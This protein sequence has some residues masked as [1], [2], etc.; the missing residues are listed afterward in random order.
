MNYIGIK[1]I[2]RV[3]KFIR[4]YN[5]S[6][7]KNNNYFANNILV[8]NCF[9]Y[10][11][12][13][14][15]PGI[16]NV[17][18]KSV[19]IDRMISNLNGKATDVHGKMFY[20]H[21]YRH[22]FVL[23]WGGLADPFCPFEKKNG[24]G[25][26]LIK[27]LGELNY[28]TLFSFKGDAIFGREYLKTFEKH[29]T[30]QNFAFQVSMVTADDGI[31]KLIE[32]GVPSPSKRFKIMKIL[33]DMGYWTILRLRPFIVG[34][35]D[36]T[37]DDLLGR[38]LAAGIRA[39]SVEFMAID[40][41]ANVGMKSRYEWI[42]KLVGVQ[43]LQKYFKHTSPPERGGYMRSNRL[44]KEPFIKKIYKFCAK[45]NLV[46]GVSDPDFKELNTT[47]SCCGMPNKFPANHLLENWTRSQTT[48]HLK[49]ARQKFYKTKKE[50]DLYFNQVYGEE[51]YLDERGFAGDHVGTIG[52]CSAVTN[53]LTHRIMLQERWNNLN[54]PACPKNYFHGKV[55]PHG[56]DEDGNFIF[57][58]TP[59]DYEQ[60]WINE[61]IDLTR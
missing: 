21:F 27:A 15:N 33:S 41:R 19:D 36:E 58:Y 48:Y 52:E 10:F 16:K 8:H 59:M 5:I 43:N 29:S 26:R 39:V 34:L 23:H 54:S 56:L 2:Q 51:S 11:F 14:N 4:V 1:Q 12:K 53:Q 22:K 57:R 42:A 61:G 13:S 35:T 60:R 25:L 46:L 24:T 37:L 18:L 17:V 6:T 3:K 50:Q 45:N 7:A 44:I 49:R 31:A 28:P 55:L 47:G 32:I 9:S 30:Q 38:A 40:G 20:E